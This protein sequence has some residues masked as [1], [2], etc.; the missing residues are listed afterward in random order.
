MSNRC[1]AGS[2]SVLQAKAC[3]SRPGRR[4]GLAQLL[5]RL[6]DVGLVL[7]E[8]GRRHAANQGRWGAVRP[9]QVGLCGHSFGAITTLGMAGQRYPKFEGINEPRL[10]S[11][12]ALSP[13]IP[14]AGDAKQ[15]FERMT[16]PLLSVT[17][18]PSLRQRFVAA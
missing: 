3:G 6:R 11:F 2:S 13:S 16:R 17:G 4:R 15:A 8:I 7:D 18:T 12:I 14:S 10:A 5:A 1:Q 9:V